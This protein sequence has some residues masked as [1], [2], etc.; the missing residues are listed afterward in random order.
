MKMIAVANQKGGV[1]KTTVCGN[2]AAEFARRDLKTLMIDADPQGSLSSWFRIEP[3]NG[4]ELVDVLDSEEDPSSAI[5][6]ISGYGN[7]FILPTSPK[8]NRLREFAETALVGKPFIFMDLKEWLEERFDAVLC[9]L[10]PS[11][12]LLE[13]FLLAAA[14]EIVI[15][16]KAEYFSIEGLE[17]L[18]SFFRKTL[19]TLRS[20]A[21][22]SALVVNEI[23]RTIAMHKN[24]KNWLLNRYSDLFPVLLYKNSVFKYAQDRGVFFRDL[25]GDDENVR[26]V[27][28]L[29]GFLCHTSVD[30][31][32]QKQI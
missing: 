21:S 32:I 19:K 14:D 2:L 31:A 3:E 27:S 4:G 12:S 10:S 17:K 7:L 9:D 5:R 22:V 25:A 29:A 26:A 18:L 24:Y 16:T 11:S 23:D 13:K 8:G 6:E 28:D 30:N 15:V 1:G 20:S